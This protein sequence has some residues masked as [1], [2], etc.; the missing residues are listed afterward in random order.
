[1][2]LKTLRKKD[3]FL[4]L[5]KFFT[6]CLNILEEFNKIFEYIDRLDMC[7]LINL[8]YLQ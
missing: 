1:M 2:S 8:S 3:Q 5:Y 6:A 7:S 4:N